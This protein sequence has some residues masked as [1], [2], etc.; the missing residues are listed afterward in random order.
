ME[1]EQQAEA[2]L[3]EAVK[4]A[5][6]AAVELAGVDRPDPEMVRLLSGGREM[7]DRARSRLVRRQRFPV[8]A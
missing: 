1:A 3:V 8:A 7:L 2:A 6:A 4:S 5:D